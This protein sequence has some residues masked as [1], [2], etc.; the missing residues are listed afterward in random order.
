M[1]NLCSKKHFEFLRV[2]LDFTG[3]FMVD[4]VG[5]SGGL[6]LFWRE[7]KEVEIYNYSRRHISAIVQ[8][9]EEPFYWKLTSFYGHPDAAKREESWALLRHLRFHNP[10]P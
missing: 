6:A 1:E 2:K 5:H 7:A 10:I 8:S 9:G 3:L 4:P